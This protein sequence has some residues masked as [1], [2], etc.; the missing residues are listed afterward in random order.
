MSP[1]AGLHTPDSLRSPRTTAASSTTTTPRAV[2]ALARCRELVEPALRKAVQGLHPEPGRIAAHAFGWCDADGTPGVGSGG[3]GVRPALAVL[4]TQAVGASA[5]AAVPAAVAIELIHTFSLMH[6][7]IMDGDE[8]RR[9]RD[10]SW[11]AFG[12]GPAV[13][14]GDALFALAVRTV[15]EADDACGA[16]AVRQL[17]VMLGELVHGQADDV[18]FETRPWTGP[19][20]VGLAEYR[21]MAAR[22]TGSLLGCATALGPVLAG[23][24]PRLADALA[25]AGREWGLAFQAVD[26]VLGIWGD[27]EVTGK[28]VHSDLRRGKKTLPVLAAMAAQPSLGPRLEGLLGG[29]TPPDEASVRCAA[30]LVEEAGGRAYALRDAR[31]RVAAARDRLRAAPLVTR[32]V[33]DLVALSELFLDRRV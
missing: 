4:G 24:P 27:P 2:A 16:R 19:H 23:A 25:Q 8:R 12:S 14:A 21:A 18:L 1:Q 9:G 22:K 17:A 6:D 29:G 15:A 28:P 7:D 31:S 11:K 30:D 32:R 20:A 3:K 13:L 33:D 10:S 26:D 5:D